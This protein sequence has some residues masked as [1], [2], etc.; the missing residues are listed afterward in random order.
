MKVCDYI[1][2]GKSRLEGA[3]LECADPLL[4]MRQMVS[5]GMGWTTTQLYLHWEETLS[6]EALVKL[7]RIV[8]RRLTGEPYQY[9]VGEEWFW[10][11]R[12]RVGPGVLIPRRETELLVET[13]LQR[14]P[15]HSFKVAELGAGSG[16]IGIT[17]LLE[18]P[19]WEWH[20]F[21]SNEESWSYL[22][23]NRRELLPG[24]AKYQIHRGDFFDLASRHG[25]YDAILCNPPYVKQ[26]EWNGLSKEVRSEPRIALDGGISGLEVVSRLFR[27]SVFLLSE[28]GL[29]ALE[30][31]NDQ[32]EA[33]RQLASANFFAESEVL[34]DYA[35]LPR[36]F[37]GKRRKG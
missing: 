6:S 17:C 24:S 14:C 12:F 22:D 10:K 30:I 3:R 31:G 29:L 8:E 18:R 27:E 21:E 37:W 33:A 35:G 36:L 26:V 34:R 4:H 15:S 20:G 19:E 11:S 7:E 1:A 32:E 16:N 13:A 5:A 2:A 23:A 28:G 25:P 9:I